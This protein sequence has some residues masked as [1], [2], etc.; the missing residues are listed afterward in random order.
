MTAVLGRLATL[1]AAYRVETAP[2]FDRLTAL[3]PELA[4][5]AVI[6][7]PGTFDRISAGTQIKRGNDGVDR[8]RVLGGTCDRE[9]PARL[10]VIAG[11]ETQRLNVDLETVA[12]DPQAFRCTVTGYGKRVLAEDLRSLAGFGVSPEVLG[13]LE[14]LV[15]QLVGPDKLIGLADC[16]TSSGGRTWTLHVAHRNTDEAQRVAAK[17]RIIAVAESLGVTVAQRS[18]IDGLHDAF[19]DGRESYSWLRIRE[20]QPAI[21]LG[22]LW[23]NVRW[24]DVVNVTVNFDPKREP[25][26]RLGQ[27]SGALGADRAAGLELELGSTEPPQTRVYV[28]LTNGR[29]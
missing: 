27:L 15:P 1:G 22:V 13:R 25:G 7:V 26:T 19:V 6:S 18:V 24:E 14:A 11:P 2:L 23:S 28:T 4:E 20:H 5:L 3:A 17:Q 10:A 21:Q 8:L 9:Q 16:A 12:G 29:A